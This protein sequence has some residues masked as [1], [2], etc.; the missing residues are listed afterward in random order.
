MTLDLPGHPISTRINLDQI[1]GAQEGPRSY[2]GHIVRG[3][4]GLSKSVLP[5]FECSKDAYSDPVSGAP[6]S[7]CS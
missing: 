7:F 6:E 1:Q 4:G 3:R 2:E 5:E